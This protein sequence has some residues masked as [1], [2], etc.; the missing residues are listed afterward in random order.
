MELS[1]RHIRINER[2]LNTDPYMEWGIIR[3]LA[4]LEIPNRD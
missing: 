1:G 4:W 2:Y 3:M